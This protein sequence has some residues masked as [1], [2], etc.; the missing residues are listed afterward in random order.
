MSKLM[1]LTLIHPRIHQ[2]LCDDEKCIANFWHRIDQQQVI[3]SIKCVRAV[4]RLA[5]ARRRRNEFSFQSELLWQCL[6]CS[7]ANF[8][9]Y[10]IKKEV[11]LRVRNKVTKRLEQGYF[12]INFS[13][14]WSMVREPSSA[15]KYCCDFSFDS[16]LNEQL[17]IETL[18]RAV[19]GK[20]KEN[21]SKLKVMKPSC[22]CTVNKWTLTYANVCVDYQVVKATL[23]ATKNLKF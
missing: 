6:S 21:K 19:Q 9:R 23:H 12:I 8:H 4:A 7:R 2:A 17:R 11:Q 18:K 20:K 10:E 15:L 3:F 22:M 14:N 16:T 5:C 13:E 1:N